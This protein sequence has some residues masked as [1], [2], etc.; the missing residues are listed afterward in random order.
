MRWR[1]QK[2]K[3]KMVDEV[4]EKA[5]TRDEFSDS[6]CKREKMRDERN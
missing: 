2:R 6:E 4:N 1:K 5:K 3:G